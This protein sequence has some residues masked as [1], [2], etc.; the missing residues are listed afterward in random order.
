MSKNRVWYKNK[1]SELGS[2]A[3]TKQYSI[4]YRVYID[5][6]QYILYIIYNILYIYYILYIVYSI[7]YIYTI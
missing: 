1:C 6:I 2:T 7:Y 3:Y 5:T 4:Y